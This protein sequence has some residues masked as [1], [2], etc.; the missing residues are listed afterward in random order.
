MKICPRCARETNQAGLCPHCGPP[1]P[2]PE[3]TNA[4]SQA[5]DDTASTPQLAPMPPPASSGGSSKPTPPA[6][7][8][9]RANSWR[10]GALATSVI[11]IGGVGIM[12]SWPV[13]AVP[14][15]APQPAPRRAAPP[16]SP[17]P[18]SLSASSSYAPKWIRTPQPKWVADKLRTISFEL[19]A[20][21]DVSVWMKRVRPTLAVR[22]LSGITEVF[23]VMDSAASFESLADR[24]TVQIAFDNETAAAQQWLDSASHTELFA[25]DGVAMA[26]QI[27]GAQ[28][29]RFRFTPFNSSPVLVEFD[30]RGFSDPL[31]SVAKTC[32][33]SAKQ[34]GA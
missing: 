26:R 13:R 9:P 20:E 25:P 7:A 29:L 1:V 8:A 27:A 4:W 6:K 28:R 34:R 23:V 18:S 19:E 11:V 24:H 31:R 2:T 14:Q 32:G 33:W 30:V 15:P 22:C 10:V 16:T 12:M 5:L 21:N 3:A 17:A